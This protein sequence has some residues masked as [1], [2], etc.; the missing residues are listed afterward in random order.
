MDKLRIP[1]IALP[2][3]ALPGHKP[4]AMPSA[5]RSSLVCWYSP[6]RQG[7]TNENMAETP[8]LRDLSGRGLHMTCHNFAWTTQ[9]GIAEDG[10]MIFDGVDDYGITTNFPSM[11]RDFTAIYKRRFYKLPLD[12]RASLFGNDNLGTSTVLFMLTHNPS[13]EGISVLGTII[14]GFK[15]A[16]LNETSVEWYTPTQ[17]QTEQQRIKYA[18]GDFSHNNG[19]QLLSGRNRMSET[20]CCPFI[21]HS[22][23]LFSRT[24]TEEEI[25]WVKLNMID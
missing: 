9:S 1:R 2:C 16:P 18:P 19:S 13:G 7:C 20:L 23:I 11:Y 8:V 3:V 14:K 24:L 10:S 6:K 22:F 12:T 25:E 17:A 21:L 4:D 15:R 5:I